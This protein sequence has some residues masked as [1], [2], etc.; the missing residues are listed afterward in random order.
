M[1]RVL[2]HRGLDLGTNLLGAEPSNPYG[3]FEDIDVIAMHDAALAAHDLTWKSPTPCPRP[4]GSLTDDIARYIEQRTST[5]HD[6]WGIKDPRLCL[7]LGQWLTALPQAKV[8]VVVR[9]PGAAIDSLHRR[10]AQRYVDT[11][12]SDPTDLAFWQDPDLGLRLWIHYHEQLLAAL[13]GTSV[14]VNFEDR[15]G[16]E[17]LPQTLNDRWGL[18]F[19]TGDVS[20]LDADLGRRPSKPIEVRDGSLID[21]ALDVW[22]KLLISP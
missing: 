4:A 20:Q 18:P 9:E 5:P 10:H 17:A 22:G 2:Q 3:H 8:V 6:L 13:P 19:R 12:H 7:F 11:R 1:A 21:S 15:S 16:I 14:V